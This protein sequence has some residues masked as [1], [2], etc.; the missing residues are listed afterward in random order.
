[1]NSKHI[2]YSCSTWLAYDICQRYYGQRHYVW[3]SPFFDAFS[4]FSLRNSVPPSSSPR[5]IYWGLKKD[6][7][8]RDL[9]S[10][11]IKDIRRGLRNGALLK[12]KAGMINKLEH[13]EILEIVKRAQLVDFL[14]L[15]FVIPVAPVRHLL[16]PV[17]VTKRANLFSEEYIIKSL[18]RNLFDAIEL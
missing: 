11:K 13:Q 18:P 14:P 9:H 1:M 5:D 8:T 15:M 12:Y 2:Y 17:G 10:S 7:D 4:C 16:V 3:C 6:V